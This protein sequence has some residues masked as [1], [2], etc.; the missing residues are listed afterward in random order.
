MENTKEKQSVPEYMK[1]QTSKYWSLDKWIK[2]CYMYKMEYYTAVEVNG[3][4]L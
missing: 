3:L 1:P 4:Y 2:G